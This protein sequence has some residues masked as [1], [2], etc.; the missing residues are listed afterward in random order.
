[1][2]RNQLSNHQLQGMRA[3]PMK[4]PQSKLPA[5]NHLDTNYHNKTRRVQESGPAVLV[6]L[7]VGFGLVALPQFRTIFNINSVISSAAPIA[8]LAIGMTVVLLTAEID[9]SV[10]SVMSLAS[11]MLATLMEGK[12]SEMV[13]TIAI[14]LVACTFVG[15]IN[16][17]LT[18]FVRIPS[19]ITTLAMLFI[20]DGINLVWTNGSPPSGLAPRFTNLALAGKG[21]FTTGLLVTVL[22]T[23]VSVILLNRTLTGRT[24]YLIGSNSR[25][26][27]NSGLPVKLV[28]LRAFMISGLCAGLAG[29]YATSYTGSG[30][31]FLGTGMEL[32]AIAA[33]VVGGVNLFGGKGTTLNAV[34]GAFILAVIFDIL[35]LIGAPSEVQPIVTGI[36]LVIGVVF[37]SRS[38]KATT[39]IQKMLGPAYNKMVNNST[40]DS[41]IDGQNVR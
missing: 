16:G 11:V 21:I 3:I 6:I 36:V 40:R 33:A 39:W 18:V 27:H 30:E 34:F 20:I 15:L 31:T 17:I 19:F 23:Y 35:L 25:S 13:P 7:L 8:L 9:L 28:V 29:I 37:Y 14:T 26:A 5:I 4:L 12:N 24:L 41:R 2:F 22:A 38:E 32:T 1:M 10:G